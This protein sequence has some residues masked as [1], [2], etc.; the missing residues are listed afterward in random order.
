MKQFV[1][2]GVENRLPLDKEPP[3]QQFL[4]WMYP[5]YV[6]R[7]IITFNIVARGICSEVLQSLRNVLLRGE[8]MDVEEGG[9]LCNPIV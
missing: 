9:P 3:V 4:V 8:S 2:P 7:C 6:G 5:K 1:I